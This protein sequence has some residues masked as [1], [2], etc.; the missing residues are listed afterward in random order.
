MPGISLNNCFEADQINFPLLVYVFRFAEGFR[1]N[2]FDFL[3]LPFL[4]VMPA[5]AEM[6]VRSAGAPFDIVVWSVRRHDQLIAQA[7]SV[8]CLVSGGEVVSTCVRS[9]ARTVEQLCGLLMHTALI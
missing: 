6:H 8:V 3:R 7:R 9:A 2:Y 4:I 1:N 5:T